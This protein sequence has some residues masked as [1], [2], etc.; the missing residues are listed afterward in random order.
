MK[1]KFSSGSRICFPSESPASDILI[2]ADVF[3]SYLFDPEATRK[4]HNEHGY[5]AT[6]DIARRE[7]DYYFIL[8]RSSI[9][10]E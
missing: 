6:G 10:S 2:C 3:H 7:G 1:A 5:F 8:G 9:D 4:A